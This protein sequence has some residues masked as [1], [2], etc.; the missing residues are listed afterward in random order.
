ML[1]IRRSGLLVSLMVSGALLVGICAAPACV[2]DAAGP[3][4]G[5]DTGTSDTGL[6]DAGPDSGVAPDAGS[7]A[8]SDAACDPNK[9]FGSPALLMGVN[10]AMNESSA[11]LSPDE[12]TLYFGAT[13]PDG[14]VGSADIFVAH[15]ASRTAAFDPSVLLAKINTNI[16]EDSPSISQDGLTLL[17]TTVGANYDLELT[18]RASVMVD[19]ASPPTSLS[20]NTVYA[21]VTGFLTA[22]GTELWF[23]SNRNGSNYDLFLAPRSGTSIGN[24]G[25]VTD[26]NTPSDEACPVVSADGLTAF[27][28]STRADGAAKGGYDVW[29]SSRATKNG[30][31]GP[32]VNLAALNTNAMENPNWVSPDG[33]RLYF[34]SDRAG[35][36]DLYVAERGK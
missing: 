7:D 11:S 4:S 3:D 15:R 23:A 19:F 12:L 14:G 8:G 32:A 26:L 29:T 2:G 25:A 24:A 36:A 21:E 33:C 16:Y 34:M 17:Y 22:D 18:T 35:S 20:V 6:P 27:W 9:A 5:A 31:F 10:T 1:G 13:R 28:A 30:A